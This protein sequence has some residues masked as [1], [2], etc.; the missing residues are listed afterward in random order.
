MHFIFELKS[1][2]SYRLYYPSN[3]ISIFFNEVDVGQRRGLHQLT[4]IYLF[5]D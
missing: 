5:G 3:A 1:L 2:K 4:A